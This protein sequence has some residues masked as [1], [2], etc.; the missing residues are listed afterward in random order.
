ML[1]SVKRLFEDKLGASDGEIGH[2]KDLYFDDENWA[3]R[4]GGFSR[5]AIRRRPPML[6]AEAA[7]ND[8]END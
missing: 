4:A 2:V 3:V 5:C 6:R 8:G 1:Q 7:I